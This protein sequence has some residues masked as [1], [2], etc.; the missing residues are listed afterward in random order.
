MENSEKSSDLEVTWQ[1]IEIA[2]DDGDHRKVIL[3]LKRLDRLG[4]WRATSRIGEIYELGANEVEKN[5][6]EAVKW[7]RKAVFESDDPVAHMGLGRIYYQGCSMVPRDLQKARQ[8]L[9][10]AYE[11]DNPQAGIYLGLMSMFGLGVEKNLTTAEMFF[12]AAAAA[13]FPIAYTY[14]ANTSALS[15][16]LFKSIIMLG[17][18]YLLTAKLKLRDRSHPNL[19][20][21]P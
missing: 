21:L 20:K 16:K 7:Y 8:H 17:K 1:Q 6:E 15:G 9:N 4:V 19:W 12:S 3:L 10:K 14:L 5:L 13:G 11:N 18:G 2:A